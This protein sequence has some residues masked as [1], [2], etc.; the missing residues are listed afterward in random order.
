MTSHI[1]ET[2]ERKNYAITET[3]NAKVHKCPFLVHFELPQKH[4]TPQWVGLF[5]PKVPA[6]IVANGI[7]N[8]SLAQAAYSVP[9]PY[10]AQKKVSK[11]NARCAAVRIKICILTILF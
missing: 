6:I 3:F 11:Q 10:T 9:S 2:C 7:L 8:Y 4:N 5:P 1:S